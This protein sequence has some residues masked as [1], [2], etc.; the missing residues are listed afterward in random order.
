MICP[1]CC[2]FFPSTFYISCWPVVAGAVHSFAQPPWVLEAAMRT[3]RTLWGTAAPKN[4]LLPR[5]SLGGIW[6]S[7]SGQNFL[8]HSSLKTMWGSLAMCLG[9]AGYLQL[10]SGWQASRRI[11]IAIVGTPMA[12][13]V[14]LSN[15]QNNPVFSMIILKIFNNTRE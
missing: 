13:L 5:Q 14:K 10:V 8:V 6:R 4:W 2:F 1:M 12:T 15:P 9:K 3:V 11:K 7:C